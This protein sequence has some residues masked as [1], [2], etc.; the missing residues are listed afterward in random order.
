MYETHKRSIIKGITWRI[1]ASATTMLVVFIVTGNLML[2][3]S[4]GLVDV[5][6]KVFFY[7]LHERVWGKVHWGVLGTEP[8][9]RL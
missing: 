3:A 4:V 9:V 2:V 8:G 7:Y 5:S 6:A 1:I